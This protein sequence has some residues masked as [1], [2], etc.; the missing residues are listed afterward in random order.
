LLSIVKTRRVVGSPVSAAIRGMNPT[1][2]DRAFAPFGPSRTH[3]NPY[4]INRYRF[5]VVGSNLI[6]VNTGSIW[7]R[8]VNRF[9]LQYFIRV[10]SV[11]RELILL[12]IDWWY[13]MD[14]HG[15]P[16]LS[17]VSPRLTAG[18]AGPG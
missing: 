10:T 16:L 12:H 8:N 13:S 5:F 15:G 7:S 2:P 18:R 1:S 4:G 3:Y 14:S 11:E 17:Q 6:D 9:F